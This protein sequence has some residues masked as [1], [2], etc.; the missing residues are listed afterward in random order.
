M[1][2]CDGS[3]GPLYKKVITKFKDESG[4][5]RESIVYEETGLICLGCFKTPCQEDTKKGL[6]LSE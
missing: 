6:V 4:V 1:N 5:E 3:V 2:N